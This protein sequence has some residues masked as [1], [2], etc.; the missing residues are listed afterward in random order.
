MLKSFTMLD[1]PGGIAIRFPPHDLHDAKHGT[2]D[3]SSPFCYGCKI[4]AGATDVLTA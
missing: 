3:M 1:P 4:R 2:Q